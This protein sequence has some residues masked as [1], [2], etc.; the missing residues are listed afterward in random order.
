MLSTVRR[1][2][3]CLLLALVPACLPVASYAQTAD[4]QIA[5]SVRW[6]GEDDR[7]L[8]F[9]TDAEVLEFLRTAEVVS[10]KELAGTTNRPLKVK[11][12]QG[13]V[14]ANAIFRRVDVFIPRA[15]IDGKPILDFHDSHIY[16]CAAWEVSR[17]LGLDHVPPCVE[18]RHRRLDGTMQLWIEN[19][20]TELKRRERDI[21]PPSHLEWVRQKQTMRLFDA[22][23]YNFD[24]NQGNMLI[25]SRWKLWFIDHTRSFRKSPAIERPERIVWVEREVY[26][27]LQQLEKRT[28]AKRLKSIHG[29]RVY[30]LL[31]RRDSLVRHVE[32]LIA[33][34]G[35][36]AV[37][38]DASASDSG[39]GELPPG[40]L[41]D[42]IPETSSQPQ[43]PVPSDDDIP[44][45]SSRPTI[46]NPPGT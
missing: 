14:E 15:K 1:T 29:H 22:L 17:L 39:V 7:P 6:W 11:L 42:D 28:L 20:M 5:E 34:S 33:K 4:D 9:T 23:I 21:D 36:E 40:L 19:A 16:E 31:K 37:V 12:R 10:E 13:D 41:D 44:E 35:E 25:D 27:R 8:P 30:M 26:E 43:I 38:W 32:S 45:T 46:P 3:A 24:R 18:R 2:L